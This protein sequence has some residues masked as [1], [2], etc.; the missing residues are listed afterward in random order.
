V[1]TVSVTARALRPR[2]LTIAAACPS[3]NWWEREIRFSGEQ[4]TSSIEM[5]INRNAVESAP[6]ERQLPHSHQALSATKHQRT[7]GCVSV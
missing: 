1:L 2:S 6:I 3:Q 4:R 5:V 7:K